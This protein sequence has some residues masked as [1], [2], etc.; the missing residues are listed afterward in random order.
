M[1]N[2]LSLSYYLIYREYLALI[3]INFRAFYLFNG[4][5]VNLYHLWCDGK[6][7]GLRK[8]QYIQLVKVLY[9]RLMVNSKQPSAF[10]LDDGLGFKLCSLRHGRRMCHGFV[11][12]VPS[13][14][15]NY[16]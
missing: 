15:I 13:T 16:H 3:K 12:V 5:V 2:N 1:S 6:L 7:E 4:E 11:S 8:N 14:N 9:W 10:P